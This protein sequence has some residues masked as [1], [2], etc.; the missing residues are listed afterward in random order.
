MQAFRDHFAPRAGLI[1]EINISLGPAGELRYP[2][3]NAHDWGNYPNRGT[4]Q[5]YSPLAE[6]DWR[7]YLKTK[8]GNIAAL[9]YAFGSKFEGFEA[10]SYNF[11]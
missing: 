4:L 2:S 6:K 11:V 3:Y 9:N 5:C 1:D 10:V 8:Y 7:R